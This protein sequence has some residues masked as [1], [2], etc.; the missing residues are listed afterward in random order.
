MNKLTALVSSDKLKL[1]II[2][3]AII[4]LAVDAWQS[5][6]VGDAGWAVLVIYWSLPDKPETAAK[7]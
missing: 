6:S 3:V 5:K 2:L 7:K 1:A 4:L